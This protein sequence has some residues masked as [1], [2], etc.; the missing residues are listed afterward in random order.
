[1]PENVVSA[2]KLNERLVANPFNAWMGLKIVELTEETIEISLE[3]REEMISNPK[4]RVTHG[5]ILGALIDVAADFM[6][7]AKVGT[8]VPT[9]DLRVD[10][11]RAATPGNLKA[12]GR[13]VRLGS[14]NS[15]AEAH[16][17]DME[18]RLI[19]SGRGVYFTAAAKNNQ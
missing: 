15:V 9:V 7:G 19:A 16:I 3:W 2:E 14:T 4:A 17:Y 13:I 11:H 1:M 6:I 8:P 5:G 10:Y 12:I 18:E